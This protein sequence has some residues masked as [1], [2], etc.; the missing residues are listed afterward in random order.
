MDVEDLCDFLTG[1]IAAQVNGAGSAGTVVGVSGG[2]DSATVLALC[3]RAVGPKVLGLVMPCHSHKEDI[4]DAMLVLDHFGV[5][6][7]V[8]V[9][10][11]AF[12]ELMRAVG[13]SG[14]EKRDLCVANVRPRLRMATL[15]YHA[16]KLNYLVVGT[17]NR[18]E[19]EVGYF[20]KYGDGGVDILPLGGL[21][22]SQVRDLAA[23]LGVPA[24][25][26]EKPPTAGLWPGQ[27][28]EG[29][30]GLTY[31]DIDTY[32]LTG[33]GDPE[34]VARIRL[35]QQ[36]SAHKRNPLPVPGDR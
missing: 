5:E 33:K 1:W 2:V 4:D 18:S 8:V 14:S 28:D 23:H 26:I 30:M 13:E 34:T 17:G 7:K 35:M 36:R 24:R 21:V 10:D 20:T 3:K 29:E 22:K 9:L 19:L 32:L 11:D 12:D 27:T 25:I 16:N 15:Y 31:R 6:R